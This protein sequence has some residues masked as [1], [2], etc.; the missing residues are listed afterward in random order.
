M[1]GV[2][3]FYRQERLRI[4]GVVV[5]FVGGLAGAFIEDTNVFFV[6]PLSCVGFALLLEFQCGH[7]QC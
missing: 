2:A 6:L 7:L 5:L 1:T 4:I 3:E